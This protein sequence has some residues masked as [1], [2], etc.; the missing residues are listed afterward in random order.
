MLAIGEGRIDSGQLQAMAKTL[1]A[2]RLFRR[3]KIQLPAPQQADGWFS[4]RQAEHFRFRLPGGQKTTSRVKAAI[5]SLDFNTPVQI[6]PEGV[7]PG[8]RMVAI[9]SMDG[10]LT[11]YPIHSDALTQQ[12]EAEVA[13]LDV[14][15]DANYAIDGL[16]TVSI[17]MLAADRPGMLAQ[18]TA[19]I[20][21]SEANIHNLVLRMVSPDFH[22][23]QPH[24]W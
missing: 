8:D 16:H 2:R 14:L 4:L 15:W 23:K 21:T 1:G 13:W 12:H 18:V 22:Q 6:S 5:A 9:L 11:V 20:A 17:S 10:P 3:R 24:G 19:T 7:V